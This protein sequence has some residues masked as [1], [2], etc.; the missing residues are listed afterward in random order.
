[1]MEVEVVVK[2]KLKTIPITPDDTLRSYGAK[3]ET[4]HYIKHCYF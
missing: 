1:M 2:D 3:Q 4:E